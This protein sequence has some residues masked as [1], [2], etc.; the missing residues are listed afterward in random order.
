MS[1]GVD[2][3]SIS[4]SEGSGIGL[5]EAY[6]DMLQHGV[7]YGQPGHIVN[8]LSALLSLHSW[9]LPSRQP[10]YETLEVRHASM[11]DPIS[12]DTP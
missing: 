10:H 1:R 4:S 8:L 5:P 12:K 7:R 9:R 11:L 3:T 6:Q 2:A